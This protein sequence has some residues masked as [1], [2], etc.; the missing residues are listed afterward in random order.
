[1]EEQ[2]NAFKREL[3]AQKVESKEKIKKLKEKKLELE[4]TVKK[5][6]EDLETQ[7]MI[8]KIMDICFFMQNSLYTLFIYLFI[9]FYKIHLLTGRSE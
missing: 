6:S 5:Q 2:A 3:R 4:A 9:Y 1:L 7:V 8:L